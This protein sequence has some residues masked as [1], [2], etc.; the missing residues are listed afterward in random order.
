MASRYKQDRWYWPEFGNLADAEQASN[1]GFWAALICAVITAVVAS[2]SVFAKSAVMGIDS[3]AYV[4]ALLFAVI[5]WRIR[6]RSRGFAVAGLVLFLIEKIFQF[7]TQ[8]KAVVGILM[9]VA[10]LMAF[11][12][13]VRGTFAYHRMAAAR[14]LSPADA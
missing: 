2:I 1:A 8:P 6:R 7:A 13:G 4:D 14:E 12:T 5:A 11:I 9:A 10:L 3:M